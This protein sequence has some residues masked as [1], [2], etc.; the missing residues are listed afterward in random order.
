[1]GGWSFHVMVYSEVLVRRVDE[2]WMHCL[3]LSPFLINLIDLPLPLCPL[4]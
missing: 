2:S 4:M 1:M 3:L